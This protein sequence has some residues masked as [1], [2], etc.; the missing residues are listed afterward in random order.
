MNKQQ[1][2]DQIRRKKSFLCVGLDS[3]STLLPP[4]LPQTAEGVLTFNKAIIDAT[5]DLVV[6]YKPNEAFYEP[7]GAEGLEAL[8]KTIE[9]VHNKYPEIMVILDAKRG[10]IGNTSAQ[11]AHAAF[12]ELGAD[13]VT[14]APYMGRDSIS[15]FLEYND[16]W[17]VLLA[18]TSNAGSADF[19]H[20]R[21]E[22]GRLLYQVV[23]ET[24]TSWA[25]DEQLMF[26]AGATQAKLFDQI[27]E[28]APEYFL[29]VPGVGKQGGSLEEVC[30]Y[31]M[32]SE[33]GLIVNSSRG[34]IFASKGE[35]FAEAARAK[36][37]ALQAEMEREL[38]RHH[39]I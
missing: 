2:I 11:Y 20:L 30:N 21:L 33:C 19:Q 9:Y 26:V 5:A 23:L 8:G 7:L 32:T 13:A 16:R 18:L 35:D 27:R 39:V 17:T 22:D 14:T 29:L 24:A 38:R 3:D 15:P 12:E 10:D 28:I 34:I 4:H 1:L 37:L 6:A 25:S 36:S 31:G